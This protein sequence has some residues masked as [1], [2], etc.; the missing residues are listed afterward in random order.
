MPNRYVA[1]EVGGECVLPSAARRIRRQRARF[2]VARR[3]IVAFFL[4]RPERSTSD[5]VDSRPGALV[6]NRTVTLRDSWA[7]IKER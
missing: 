4:G 5:A 1:R 6:F 7:K 2:W 3:D